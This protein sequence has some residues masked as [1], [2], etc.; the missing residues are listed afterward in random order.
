LQ[1]GKN[2][3]RTHYQQ[4]SSYNQ[5][6]PP[7]A[8]ISKVTMSPSVYRRLNRRAT[9]EYGVDLFSLMDRDASSALIALELIDE[10]HS[11]SH[12]FHPFEQCIIEWGIDYKRSGNDAAFDTVELLSKR[13]FEVTVLARRRM[14][15]AMHGWLPRA[16]LV[17]Y[18]TFL[19][20]A[21][22]PET[23]L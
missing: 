12:V 5:N 20:N 15:D 23:G 18:C 9:K 13:E 2:N 7:I 4:D 8:D 14:V 21:V 17:H 10:A 11:T 16:D 6:M 22:S 3:K 1:L 19:S